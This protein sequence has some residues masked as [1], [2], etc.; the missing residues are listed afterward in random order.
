MPPPVCWGLASIALTARTLGPELLGILALIEAYARLVDRIV[1]PEPWQAIIRYGAGMLQERRVDD[2]RRLLKFGALID[3]GGAVAAT[4]IAVAGVLLAGH[5]FGWTDETAEMAAIYS[6]ALLV[7]LGATPTAVLRLFDR[8][9]VFA[10]VEIA[11][12]AVRLALVVVAWWYQSGLW[13]FIVIAIAAVVVRQV[14]LMA[15]AWQE[16]DRHGHAGF[17]RARARGIGDRCAGIWGFVW[18]LKGSVLLRRGTGEL[19]VLIIGA[20]LD[21]SA[22]GLYQVAK[23]L[24]DAGLKL[25]TAVRQAVFPEVSRLWH[26]GEL[27]R[28]RPHR[29]PDQPGCRRAF[30]R[31]PGERRRVR[32]P[33][34]RAGVRQPLPG[35]CPASGPAAAVD[36][37]CAR[38]H[39]ALARTLEHGQAVAPARDRHGRHGGL[40]RHPA[41]GLAPPRCARRQPGARGPQRSLAGRGLRRLDPRPQADRGDLSVPSSR[42]ST[43]E[44]GGGFQP[45]AEGAVQQLGQPLDVGAVVVTEPIVHLGWQWRI[46]DRA[47]HERPCNSEPVGRAKRFDDPLERLQP[48]PHLWWHPRDGLVLDPGPKLGRPFQLSHADVR[49]DVTERG[50]RRRFDV[51]VEHHLELLLGERPEHVHEVAMVEAIVHQPR[52]R[53]PRRIEVAGDVAVHL[54]PSVVH[55]VVGIGPLDRVA[56][57]RDQARVGQEP[58]DS[59]PAPE[60]GTCSWRISR[61]SPVRAAH[62]RSAGDTRRSRGRGSG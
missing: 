16:L 8:F 34:H 48:A 50:G 5:L 31:P 62:R 23:R 32:G 22:V 55:A 42:S 29:Q 35:R 2:F 39:R 1:R 36:W 61:Q 58:S 52:D 18:S 9:A 33:G 47:G 26:R 21:A 17:F 19:D 57:L 7:H 56:Q 59:L 3:I 14:T 51:V 60:D 4:G 49:A 54:S 40:L 41:T 20:L 30:R 28:F 11:Q 6:L 44:R 53:G 15:L 24:G 12:A 45:I 38:R 10:W 25:G 27:Q 46:V 43:R 37:A 13:T